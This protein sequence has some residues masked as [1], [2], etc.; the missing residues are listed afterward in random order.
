MEMNFWSVLTRFRGPFDRVVKWCLCDNVPHGRIRHFLTRALP[1]EIAS[2][3]GSSRVA[4]EGTIKPGS[5]RLNS[6]GPTS[7]LAV[8]L[9]G[10][11]DRVA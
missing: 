7:M 5:L 11:N 3:I 4:V 8:R 6:P 1:C 10:G 9:D 2:T